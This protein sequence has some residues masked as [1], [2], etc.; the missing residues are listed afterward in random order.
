MSKAENNPEIAAV[1]ITA[2]MPLQKYLLTD[3]ACL[4][5]SELWRLSIEEL[6]SKLTSLTTDICGMMIID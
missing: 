1:L 6:Q 4:N 2:I 5:V 3:S